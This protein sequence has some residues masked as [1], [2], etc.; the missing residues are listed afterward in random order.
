MP[1]FYLEA[2]AQV[3]AEAAKVCDV[4]AVV[5]KNPTRNGK[6]RRLDL[7]TIVLLE[8]AGFEIVCHHQAILF[9]EVEQGHLFEG[10]KKS[11]KGRMSFFRRLAWQKGRPCAAWEDV[12]I[13]VRGV[14]AGGL[15]GVVSPPYASSRLDPLQPSYSN[16]ENPMYQ[17]FQ[18]PGYS[19]N[20]ANIGNLKDG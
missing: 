5:V 4:L 17:G 7:D 14:Q 15:C 8:Q 3:Y 20:P 16:P 13:C 1:E 6:L 18:P 12:L 10:R 19:D 11:V 9:E 2:M